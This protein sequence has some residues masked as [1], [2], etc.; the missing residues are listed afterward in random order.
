[1]QENQIAIIELLRTHSMKFSVLQDNIASTLR[2]QQEIKEKL[3]IL[4]ELMLHSRPGPGRPTRTNPTETNAPVLQAIPCTGRLKQLQKLFFE[5]LFGLPA[6][7]E[8][9][10]SPPTTSEKTKWRAHMD[11]DSLDDPERQH[12]SDD[13]ETDEEASYPHFPYRGGP[14][15]PWASQEQLKIM[16]H[17]LKAKG[18]KQFRMDFTA[19]LTDPVNVFCLTVA[20]DI[21]V[22]LVECGEY[23]GLQ[24]HECAPDFILKQ[25]TDYARDKFVRKARERVK[26][27]MEVQLL[28]AKEKSRSSRRVNVRNARV[29]SALEIGGLQALIPIIKSCT[30]DDETDDEITPA[31]E[32]KP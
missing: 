10:P 12:D 31:P 7:A 1:M 26:L 6:K 19:S 8:L 21:F 15:H 22:K 32:P 29:R 4:S 28:R 3:E 13:P 24:P 23:D 9:P 18:I 27:P 14:G 11:D 2:H 20:R 16:Y 30:S 5:S 17:M 25:L